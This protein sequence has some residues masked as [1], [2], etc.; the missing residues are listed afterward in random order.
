AH[1]A[2][3]LFRC[4]RRKLQEYGRLTFG[5]GRSFWP[6]RSLAK[7]GIPV[8]SAVGFVRARYS[9]FLRRRA[10]RIAA[11][12][13]RS[14][15]FHHPAG[16]KNFRHDNVDIVPNHNLESA[17]LSSTHTTANGFPSRRVNFFSTCT[18]APPI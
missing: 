4:R 18:I 16:N 12:I 6:S 15:N 9:Y 2:Q 13:D 14:P 11:R 8:R 1:F 5:R 17:V 10:Q 7:A 3:F